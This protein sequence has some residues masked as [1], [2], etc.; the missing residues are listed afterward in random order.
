MVW[1]WLLK[2]L[3]PWYGGKFAVKYIPVP[4]YG[5]HAELWENPGYLAEVAGAANSRA[6]QIEVTELIR[7]MR[8]MADN[9]ESPDRLKGVNLCVGLT[10]QLLV[11]S[12]MAEAGIRSLEARKEAEK[13]EKVGI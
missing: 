11:L 9:C 8:D 7:Q 1:R 4:S 3:W 5:Q 10:K 12:P 6:W 13:L 2:M